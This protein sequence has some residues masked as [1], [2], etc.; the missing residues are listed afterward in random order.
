MHAPGLQPRSG[1]VGLH[2]RKRR[3]LPRGMTKESGNR[4]STLPWFATI[5]TAATLAVTVCFHYQDAAAARHEALLEHRRQALFSALRV[6]DFAY[7]NMDFYGKQPLHPVSWDVQLARD[8]D[9]NM[10]IY[11][12]YPETIAT[13]RK[14]L[15]ARNPYED[16]K[17][18]PPDV[19]SLDEFRKQV[20]KELELPEPI[21]FDPKISWISSLPG[22][23]GVSLNTG[24]TLRQTQ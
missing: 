20:A 10:R 8:A 1:S 5:I 16:S 3:K 6:I 19:A 11:C 12:Q 15:G 9:N 7:A 4:T 13:F 14:A 18:N 23:V 24:E 21:G 17:P 2:G 22:A